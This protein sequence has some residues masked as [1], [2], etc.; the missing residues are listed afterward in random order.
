MNSASWPPAT[1]RKTGRW[2]SAQA[3][4][5]CLKS[6]QERIWIAPSPRPWTN[7]AS[8]LNPAVNDNSEILRYG[9]GL[10]DAGP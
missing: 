7:S 4:T 9:A 2:Q 8:A 1:S 3:C 6:G 10:T 5:A